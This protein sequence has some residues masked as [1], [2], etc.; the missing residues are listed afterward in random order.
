ME[1]FGGQVLFVNLNDSM[2]IS[3]SEETAAAK[4]LSLAMSMPT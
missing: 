1:G 3:P 4:W 2:S